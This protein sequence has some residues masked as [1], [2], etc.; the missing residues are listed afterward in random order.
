[1]Q[2]PI[3]PILTLLVDNEFGVLTRVSSQIRREGWNIRSLAVAETTDPSIS[4]I[5]LSIECFDM[6]LPGVLFKLK[7]MQC[8]KSVTAYDPELCV[9]RELAVLRVTDADWAQCEAL[10]ARYGVRPLESFD[11]TRLFEVSASPEELSEYI[12]E[13]GTLGRVEAA[14]T[15]AITLE[16]R[17]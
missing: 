12:D 4:R 13:L 10:N 6:T 8:V 2:R 16:K 17:E 11:N 1:M 7:R 5:T 3:C 9:C 15:G 14:R